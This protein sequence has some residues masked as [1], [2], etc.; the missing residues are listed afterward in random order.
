MY[1]E[2]R[3]ARANGS[4]S[5]RDM[6]L[7][8]FNLSKDQWFYEIQQLLWAGRNEWFSIDYK[9]KATDV[10]GLYK[11]AACDGENIYW[12]DEDRTHP[13]GYAE[14]LSGPSRGLDQ[15]SFHRWFG[16][17]GGNMPYSQRFVAD[18]VNT[19]LAEVRKQKLGNLDTYL[20]TL[21]INTD[22]FVSESN[23]WI[24]PAAGYVVVRSEIISLYKKDHSH[25]T[26]FRIDWSDFQ[27]LGGVM[28]PHK[29]VEQFFVYG[30]NLSKTDTWRTWRELTFSH[31][32]LEDEYTANLSDYLI[33]VGAAL[34]AGRL[35]LLNRE[36]VDWDKA[37]VE[38]KTS[39]APW[40]E[41]IKF[42][43]AP[44]P[45]ID[46]QYENP[47]TGQELKA[48]AGKYGFQLP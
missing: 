34:D 14:S 36:N 30:A 40:M 5:D 42:R 24:S 25:G 39:E 27:D 32:K 9:R 28:I 17:G 18:G 6:A 45:A 15:L 12:Y 1:D 11:R 23:I 37:L 43:S 2:W 19:R 29:C 8:R 10:Q 20:V 33:P 13:I 26:R 48:L 44:L 3:A 21:G 35:P 7:I 4:C 31:L 47:L 38:K 22:L 16:V 41:A 46:P